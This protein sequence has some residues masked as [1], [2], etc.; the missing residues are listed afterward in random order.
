MT[1]KEKDLN[2][3][4]GMIMSGQR[5]VTYKGF[6]VYLPTL[7]RDTYFRKEKQAKEEALKI[8]NLINF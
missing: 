8:Y 6:E 5:R 4:I 2:M 7:K 1:Q 3:L